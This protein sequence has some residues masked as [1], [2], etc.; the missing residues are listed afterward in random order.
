MMH[1]SIRAVVWR[2]TDRNR[3]FPIFDVLFMVVIFTNV[4]ERSVDAGRQSNTQNGSS[5][6]VARSGR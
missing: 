3:I 1:K 5:Q 6:T 4:P 2:L